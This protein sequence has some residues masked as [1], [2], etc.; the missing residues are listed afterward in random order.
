MPVESSTEQ[1]K[2]ALLDLLRAQ[3]FSDPEPWVTYARQHGFRPTRSQRLIRCPDCGAV[4]RDEIGQYVYYSPLA[5]LRLCTRCG[6]AFSDVRLDAAVIRAHFESAYKD[7]PYF[8]T[9]R[10]RVFEQLARFI[11]RCAPSGGSVL[12]I[13]GAKGHLLDAVKRRRPDLRVTLT[14]VSESACQWARTH[15]GFRTICGSITA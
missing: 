6:L 4:P 9:Q 2:R 14:D 12:D 3:G 10:R 15:Y 7:E 8:V 11:D 1:P 5:K 13:G